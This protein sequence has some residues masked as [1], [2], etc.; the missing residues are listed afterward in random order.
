MEVVRY[1]NE[2]LPQLV[3]LVSTQTQLVPPWPVFGEREVERY[4][5]G[6]CGE[7]WV[8]RYPEDPKGTT[9]DVCVVEGKEL[10]CFARC[11][12]PLGQ[13]ETVYVLD[14]FC[15]A[16]GAGNAV[17]L[18]L[19]YL[20][21]RAR[22]LG[23]SRIYLSTRRQLCIGLFGIPVTW[24]HILD[25]AKGKGYKPWQKW[26]YLSRR[27]GTPFGTRNDLAAD[28][29]TAWE[30]DT[31]AGTW[32]LNAY[33]GDAHV[34]ECTAWGPPPCFADSGV[35]A[36]WMMIEYIEVEPA[37]Q[38][39]RI[40]TCMMEEQRQLHA[41]KGAPNLICQTETSNTAAISL[42]ISMDFTV[43]PQAWEM[44]KDLGG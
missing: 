17:D 3:R 31:K 30:S 42:F 14:L 38:R 7:F 35:L 22:D 33:E 28:L 12:L 16:E 13:E 29:R 24:S 8:K 21:G 26:V 23:S 6:D 1:T 36:D 10:L 15:R 43:G 18:L 5:G 41:Q 25:K 37:Y 40:A 27:G 20:D 34:G 11:N 9:E 32:E 39:Q 4:I 19:D 44:A 2:M